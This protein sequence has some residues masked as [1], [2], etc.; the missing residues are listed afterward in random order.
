MSEQ[1]KNKAIFINSPLC[2]LKHNP[3]ES[4]V[5]SGS[6][7]GGP[8]F[9]R[10]PPP[11]KSA[12]RDARD[13]L[14]GIHPGKPAA[15]LP[16]EAGHHPSQTSRS[17]TSLASLHPARSGL[18]RKRPGSFP[19]TRPRQRPRAKVRP[20]ALPAHCDPPLRPAQ[21][22]A[23]VGCPASSSRNPMTYKVHTIPFKAIAT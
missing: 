20:V 9:R 1:Y 23:K 17:T 15:P 10:L 7:G 22:T 14:T 19:G 2:K 6:L 12:C 11:S 13:A 4:P 8:F 18:P 21:A 16:P 3:S 5:D